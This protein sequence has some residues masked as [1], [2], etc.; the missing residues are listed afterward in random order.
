MLGLL[1]GGTIEGW[2]VMKLICRIGDR[3]NARLEGMNEVVQIVFPTQYHMVSFIE[4][5]SYSRFR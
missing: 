2:D 5:G 4:R 3:W 1:R